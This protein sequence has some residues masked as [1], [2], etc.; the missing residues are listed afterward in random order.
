MNCANHA[1]IPAVAYCRNCGKALCAHCSRDVR[2]VVYCENC[3]AERIAGTAPPGAAPL[4][5]PVV[6]NSGPNP[7]VA[8]ILGAVPFGLGAIYN[9]QYV[10]GLVH[11]AIFCVLVIGAD[12]AHE[13]M[14]TVFG[15]GIAFF[16]FYQIFDAVRTAK[17]IQMG[18]PAPD[19][20][21]LGQ[22]F[23]AGE[24]FDTSRV[25]KAAIILIGLGILFLLQT[26]GILF[27][28]FDRLWP[29]LFIALGVWL[30]AR[31]LGFIGTALEWRDRRVRSGSFIG[32]AVLITFGSLSLIENLHGPGWD[33][34]WPVLLLAIGLAKLFDH[35]QPPMSP[36]PPGGLSN[37]PAQN[38]PP[39]SS[40][41]S[42]PSS[43]SSSS[44]LSSSGE[45]NN[46]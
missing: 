40:S 28:N 33:R 32:P 11:F 37:G 1:D 12:R 30:L 44:S 27:V 34:T 42:S 38:A 16:I 45:V 5:M 20:L 18:E 14:D 22:A 21:G 26:S 17:A 43:S 31:R 10:K 13:P 15:L 7:A 6:V 23:G 8:G 41:S 35:T 3:L 2:G 46:G 29:T 25:P 19:P 9:R 36:P 24:K 4:G 39:S